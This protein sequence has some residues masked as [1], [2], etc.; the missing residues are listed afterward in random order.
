MPKSAQFSYEK[1]LII[2][3]LKARGKSVY[4]ILIELN[5]SKSGIFKVLARGDRYQPKSRSG[6]PRTTSK[7]EDR[8]IRKLASNQHCSANQIKNLIASFTGNY[9]EKNQRMR[10]FNK[11]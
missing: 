10:I 2:W 6:R 8:Q 9:S 11:I 7:R 5:R 3:I 1:I 4:D